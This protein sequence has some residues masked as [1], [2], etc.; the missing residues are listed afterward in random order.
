MISKS[1]HSLTAQ[2]WEQPG[3]YGSML[4]WSASSLAE[5]GLALVGTTE[6]VT[7][8]AWACVYRL[9]TNAGS[10]YF[11]AV[12]RRF[13]H[14]VALTDK[15]HRIAPGAT[16]AVLAADRVRGWM[17]LGDAGSTLRPLV[18]SLAD[19][20]HW[21]TVLQLYAQLQIDT[22]AHAEELVSLGVPDR[23]LTTL[24]ALYP[25]I[26][27][28]SLL[29]LGSEPS[30]SQAEYERLLTLQ[31]V[32][33][34]V[35]EEL[36]AVDL[37]E[38]AQHDD[39]HDHNVFVRDGQYRVCD[40]GDACISHP[41][42]SLLVT[43]NSVGNRFQLCEPSPELGRLRDAYLEPWTHFAPRE[44]MAA[45]LPAARRLGMLSRALTWRMVLLEAPAS[46]VEE[47][48][49]GMAAW[50]QEFLSTLPR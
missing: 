1:G 41:F 4:E 46:T 36:A 29:T 17:L 12:N 18:S 48:G 15:L 39:L 19:L 44:Q 24:P 49:N 40:W 28:H 9:P 33:T 43:L 5:S 22:A 11:K 35:C 14:E 31:P 7:S 10:T 27:D 8:R 25:L 45:A 13:R 38:T 26:L 3:W 42:L 2:P 21:E 34:Q 32:V 16:T 20:H 50:A 23:R 47:L 37:P 6:V 30:L